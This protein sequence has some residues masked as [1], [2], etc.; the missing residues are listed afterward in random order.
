MW[1]NFPAVKSAY[2][3]C[4]SVPAAQMCEAANRLFLDFV[5]AVIGAAWEEGPKVTL[6][7]PF[8]P[9]PVARAS[10]QHDLRQ[11][12]KDNQ[13]LKQSLPYLIL[14]NKSIKS[15]QGRNLVAL[16]SCRLEPQGRPALQI[17]LTL[18]RRCRDAASDT[19]FFSPFQSSH[20]CICEPC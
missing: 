10:P 15:I 17:P 8:N 12:R 16:N 20:T 6:C 9:V 3:K 14:S 13:G 4:S 5:S 2:A 11:F 19:S 1:I 18:Q 7:N